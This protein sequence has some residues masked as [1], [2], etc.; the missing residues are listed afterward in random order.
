MS[1]IIP[2]NM[3]DNGDIVPM[4]IDDTSTFNLQFLTAG[5]G[6]CEES[7]VKWCDRHGIASATHGRTRWFSGRLFRADMEANA[8][9]QREKKK[10]LKDAAKQGLREADQE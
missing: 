6:L 8:L 3:F 2:K 10:E 9:K 7:T 1:Q 4:C 5:T